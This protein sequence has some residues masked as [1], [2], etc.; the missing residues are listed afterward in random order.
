MDI[1]NKRAYGTNEST[2]GVL[3]VD[4]KPFG[5]VIEDEHRDVKVKGETRI[6]AGRYKLGL[7]MDQTPL[8]ERYQKKYS[9]FKK[10]IELKDVPNFTG[11]YIHVGNFESDTAGC[12]VIGKKAH[13]HPTGFSNSESVKCFKE[14]Y[15]L[16][17][18]LL[19]RGENVYYT[20]IDE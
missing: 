16:V 13:I 3:I 2:L 9:W 10:H 7:Q 1:V 5:F 19:E 11:V 15:E 18:P 20:I 12:Q 17:Y 8:T 14:L 6:P 4:G